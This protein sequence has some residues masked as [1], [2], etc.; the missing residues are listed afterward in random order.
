MEGG[1]TKGE[2]GDGMVEGAVGPSRELWLDMPSLEVFA[3]RQDL[4]QVPRAVTASPNA[5]G[6]HTGVATA[7]DF[8]YGRFLKGIES[9]FRAH[10]CSQARERPG[11]Q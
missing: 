3:Q 6:Q 5:A 10:L 7:S 2:W 8:L 1:L 4:V 11:E 9:A